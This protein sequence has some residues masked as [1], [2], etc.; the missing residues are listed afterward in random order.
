MR[1]KMFDNAC[2]QGKREKNKKLIAIGI[3][4]ALGGQGIYSI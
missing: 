1:S 2:G 4:P 3:A